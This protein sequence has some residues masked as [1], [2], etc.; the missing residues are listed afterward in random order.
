LIQLVQS[1]GAQLPPVIALNR[2][3]IAYDIWALW[4]ATGRRFLPSQL[5]EEP[6]DLL[7][8]MITL[9]GAY[10]AIKEKYNAN[11]DD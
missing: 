4:M 6:E 7:S 11:K 10:Q 1:E 2:P 5:M 8:D 3:D 9:D